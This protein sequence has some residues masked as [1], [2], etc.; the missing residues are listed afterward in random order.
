MQGVNEN[1]KI[2][3]TGVA[4]THKDGERPQIDLCIHNRS[5]IGYFEPNAGWTVVG[6]RSHVNLLCSSG[7]SYQIQGTGLAR[8]TDHCH[9]P[10][11]WMFWQ[12]SL[13]VAMGGQ[14][15]GTLTK[16]AQGHD[17]YQ[18]GGSDGSDWYHPAMPCTERTGGALGLRMNAFAGQDAP[19][20]PVHHLVR[21]AQVQPGRR[22]G[23]R[24]VGPIVCVPHHAGTEQAREVPVAM[25]QSACATPC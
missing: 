7:S 2:R 10:P 1:R 9:A 13:C 8:V 5:I 3:F 17:R 11:G 23:A 20:G 12:E 16:S 18:L 19:T 6:H 4:W 22:D 25:P 15:T 21:A 24:V 14:G